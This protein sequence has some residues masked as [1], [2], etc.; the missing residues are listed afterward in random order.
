MCQGDSGVVIVI[1]DAQYLAAAVFWQLWCDVLTISVGRHAV[2]TPFKLRR[3]TLP[4]AAVDP[5]FT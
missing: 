1:L 2:A 3:C 4:P 5:M